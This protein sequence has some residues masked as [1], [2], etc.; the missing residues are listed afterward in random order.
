MLEK[1]LFQLA[2]NI[3]EPW[4]IESIEFNPDE[5]KL[6]IWI[7]FT[8]GSEFICPECE[9]KG[10]K[11]YDT[12]EKIWRHLNFFQYKCYI[13]CRVPR[14]KCENCGIH[15][16]KVPWSR[17]QSGF[18]LL[19]ESLIIIMAQKMPVSHISDLIGETDTRIWRVIRHYVY[20]AREIEDFSDVT[21]IGIDE[22]S[23]KKGHDYI[24]VVADLDNSK[25]LYLAHGK[26]SSTIESF[27]KDF[28]VHNGNIENISQIC[29]DMSP[30]FIHGSRENFPKAEITYDKFHVMKLVNEAVDQVRR[31]EQVGNALLKRTRYIWLKNPHNLTSKQ[32]KSLGNLKDMNLKTVRAYNIKLS[33]QIFWN[34]EDINTAVKY[35]KKWY[36]WSTHSRLEPIIAAAKSIKSHWTGVINYIQSHV[37]NGILEGL[38]S[39][40]QTLKRTAR[41]Y[42]NIKNFMT[43]V[44]L[45]L[46]QLNFRLPT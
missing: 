15:L 23:C 39:S 36:F 14:V 17:K 37:T 11:A 5:N 35:L 34:V 7:N 10:C 40:I 42:K 33:L 16:V 13:H 18:T 43:M 29:C 27:K 20:K 2:L 41:G 25:V 8:A 38:N 30:A 22:T 19:M 4:Y 21:T 45:R 44:Y 6:D 26:D 12:S 28:I 46:G 9:E 32:K 3:E 31:E 24:T 1:E